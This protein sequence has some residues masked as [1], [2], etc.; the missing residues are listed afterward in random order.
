MAPRHQRLYYLVV[1]IQAFNMFVEEYA[2]LLQRYFNFCQ[3]FGLAPL[4]KSRLSA[5]FNISQMKFAMSAVYPFL[6][7]GHAIFHV[8]KLYGKISL[9]AMSDIIHFVWMF[10]CLFTN[11][12]VTTQS[13]FVSKHLVAYVNQLCSIDT[14]KNSK[15]QIVVNYKRQSRKYF[16]ILIFLIVMSFLLSWIFY[17]FLAFFYPQLTSSYAFIFVPNGFMSIRVFQIIYSIELLNDHLDSINNRL[18][19]ISTFQGERNKGPCE[20]DLI[21]LRQ[22]YGRCWNALQLYNDCFGF[23]NLMLLLFYSVDVLHG[24]YSLFLTMNGWR[25]D[26]V[27]LCKYLTRCFLYIILL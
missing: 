18:R 11:I 21:A 20:K 9:T 16:F 8:M 12:L 22:L 26:I 4:T 7:V 27:V 3:I 25:S 19:S 1:S 23:S 24:I 10:H 5:N 2:Q 15:L 17:G 6:Q 14:E 13:L